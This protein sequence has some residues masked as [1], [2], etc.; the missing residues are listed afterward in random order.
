MLA[1]R[2]ARAGEAV[3]PTQ[4][5][6]IVHVKGQWHQAPRQFRLALELR[7]PAVGR[8]A[9]VA[10]FRGVKLKQNRALRAAARRARGSGKCF[11]GR[12]R[13][14]AGNDQAGGANGI[15]C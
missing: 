12:D 5:I 3:G 13:E 7:K 2:M 11:G 14:E 1:L 8:R 6:P 10:A 15:N 9:T 4:S